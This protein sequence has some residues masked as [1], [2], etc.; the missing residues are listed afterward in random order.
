MCEVIPRQKCH[1]PRAVSG[2]LGIYIYINVKD[3]RIG[4]HTHVLLVNL[5]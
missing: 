4:G 5:Q 3:I 1:K 2:E